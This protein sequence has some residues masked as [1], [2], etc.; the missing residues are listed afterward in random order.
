MFNYLETFVG[1]FPEE[2]ETLT[3][4]SRIFTE[5]KLNIYIEYLL[6]CLVFYLLNRMLTVANPGFLQDGG[7]NPP[8][9]TKNCMK[10][11]KFGPGAHPKFYYIDPPL[12]ELSRMISTSLSRE[13]TGTLVFIGQSVICQSV[14]LILVQ[15]HVV[16]LV[17]FSGLKH[18]GH[19]AVNYF[20]LGGFR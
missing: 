5:L 14:I 2:T 9:G 18:M 1:Y 16:L 20:D 8:G 17:L 3:A 13:M 10:L 19:G 7:A 15:T 6:T 4:I 12:A 11:Q